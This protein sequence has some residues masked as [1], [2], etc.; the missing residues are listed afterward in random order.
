MYQISL[1]ILSIISLCNGKAAS[2]MFFFFFIPGIIGYALSFIRNMNIVFLDHYV[3]E[4][5]ELANKEDVESAK[6]KAE[7]IYTVFES[8]LAGIKVFGVKLERKHNFGWIIHGK[9]SINGEKGLINLCIF[10]AK[11]AN[12]EFGKKVSKR[13]LND[14]YRSTFQDYS[15]QDIE[16]LTNLRKYFYKIQ[17]NYSKCYFEVD[18]LNS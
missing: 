10:I 17:H 7:V 2:I 8:K 11:L 12:Q 9:F 15:Y 6:L 5:N 18:D 1:K 4:A 14:E 3:M 13:N 16:K